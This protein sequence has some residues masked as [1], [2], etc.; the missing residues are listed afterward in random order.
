MRFASTLGEPTKCIYAFL[1]GASQ[2]KERNTLHMKEYNNETNCY[3]HY[4]PVYSIFAEIEECNA[5]TCI[6]DKTFDAGWKDFFLLLAAYEDT[7]GKNYK[8]SSG[9]KKRYAVKL[10]IMVP[11]ELA[12]EDLPKFVSKFL[13]DGLCVKLPFA[14]FEYKI[15]KG[16][17]VRILLSEREYFPNGTELKKVAQ[18][19]TYINS[20][21]GYFCSAK[22][23]NAIKKRAKGE[24]ISVTTVYFGLKTNAFHFAPNAF[25]E[26]VSFL[27]EE[28]VKI[29]KQ[30]GVCFKRIL[31]V[32]KVDRH[33]KNRYVQ[34]NITVVNTLITRI[35]NKIT[36]FYN[37][38]C[39]CNM[40]NSSKE[41]KRF[42]S[43]MNKYFSILHNKQ[44]KYTEKVILHLSVNL[45]H[46]KLVENCNSVF[47]AFERDF[48]KTWEEIF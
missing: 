13:K 23:N 29:L 40:A 35:E 19:D 22:D 45:D 47:E 7:Y 11:H 12:S 36:D 15:K 6:L 39:L 48:L 33:N 46:E 42:Y 43:L 8:E 4:A 24:V 25:M 38:L 9:Y 14:A 21:T 32:K 31:T 20:K 34:R 26:L 41:T 16:R 17:Y 44:Y 30:C 3:I 5:F 28:V 37:G 2:K 27:K 1:G 18:R 10:D